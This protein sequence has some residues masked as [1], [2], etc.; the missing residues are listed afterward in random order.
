M[1]DEMWSPAI[2]IQLRA[3]GHD[4]IAVVEREDLR[5]LSDSELIATASIE[6]RAIVTENAPDFRKIAAELR[7]DNVAHHGLIFTSDRRYPRHD[8]RVIGRMVIALDAI[9]R[10]DALLPGSEL[11]LT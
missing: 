1:L 11:W 8:N 6:Q 9:L 3:R 7:A 5:G 4:V 2:A 10:D